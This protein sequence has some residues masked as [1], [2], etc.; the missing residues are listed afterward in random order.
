MSSFFVF[1]WTVSEI[2]V[3]GVGEDAV[4]RMGTSSSP[5]QTT[6]CTHLKLT[7]GFVL[8]Q[9]IDVVSLVTDLGVEVAEPAGLVGAAGRV[10]LKTLNPCTWLCSCG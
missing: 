6:V 7:S 10:G 9:P 1:H 5:P 2:I 4:P 3:S 8:A